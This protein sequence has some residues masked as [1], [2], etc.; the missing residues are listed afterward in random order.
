MNSLILKLFS[1]FKIRFFKKKIFLKT[2]SFLLMK[3]R[4]AVSL[5][6]MV[7]HLSMGQIKV[8]STWVPQNSTTWV[9]AGCL[10]HCALAGSWTQE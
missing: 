7:Q 8:G 9:S 10:P 3:E 1:L 6:Q 4:S 5:P 2:T